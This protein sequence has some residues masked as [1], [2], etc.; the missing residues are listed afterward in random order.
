MKFATIFLSLSFSLNV[1]AAGFLPNASI[2]KVQGKAFIN[3]EAATVGAEIVKK[4]E[5]KIPKLGDYVVIKFNNGHRVK[6]S[7]ATLKV[8]ELTEKLAVM[9]LTKGQFHSSVKTLTS[10]EKF[11][12]KTKY[13]TFDAK[14]SKFTLMIN[15][16]KKKAYLFVSEGDVHVTKGN[17]QVDANKDQELWVDA[18]S[19]HLATKNATQDMSSSTNQ[20]LEEI[21]KI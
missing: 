16:A 17:L 14:A 1:L 10:D 2:V 5:I 7:G 3:K 21:E 20:I 9:N 11:V 19:K 13:A 8:E 6:L 15:E 18:G 4:M 12:I